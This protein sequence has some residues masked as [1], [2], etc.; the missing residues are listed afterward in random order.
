MVG[1]REVILID[2]SSSGGVVISREVLYK[3]GLEKQKSMSNAL[4]MQGITVV[5]VVVEAGMEVVAGRH[6]SHEA[7][8]R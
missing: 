3:T 8:I 6:I 5:V 7:D 4:S 1:N 2:V